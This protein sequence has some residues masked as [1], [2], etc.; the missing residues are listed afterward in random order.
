[1]ARLFWFYPVPERRLARLAE[2]RVRV[3]VHRWAYKRQQ[4]TRYPEGSDP[5]ELRFEGLQRIPKNAI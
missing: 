3:R 2:L 5:G 4:E 1:M